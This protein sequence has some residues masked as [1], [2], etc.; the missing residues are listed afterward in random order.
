MSTADGYFRSFNGKNTADNVVISDKDPDGNDV[1]GIYEYAMQNSTSLTS[2][3]LPNTVS[4]I[5]NS[6]FENCTALANISNM[7]NVEFIGNDAFAGC[8]L[9]SV[10]IPGS[11]TSI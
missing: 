11:V 5:G 2:I 1:L 10:T 8:G 9:T 3:T 6:A 7:D 4:A